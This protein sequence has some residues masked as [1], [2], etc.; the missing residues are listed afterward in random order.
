MSSDLLPAFFATLSDC[1]SDFAFEF[2]WNEENVAGATRFGVAE[3]RL[4]DLISW[5][6]I[7]FDRRLGAPNVAFSI[8]VISEFV[9]SFVEDATGFVILGCGLSEDHRAQLLQGH[10]AAVGMGEYGVYEMLEANHRFEAGGTVLGF[11]LIS[12]EYGLEHSWICNSLE[13]EVQS[14]LGISPNPNTG[15]LDPYEDAVVVADYMNRDDVGAEPGLWLPWLV[16]QY[17]I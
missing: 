8:G 2:W 4:A 9:R 13:R 14:R 15:L 7:E 17:P 11:E 1:L 5:Y 6:R 10:R 3:E 12:Y 16:V